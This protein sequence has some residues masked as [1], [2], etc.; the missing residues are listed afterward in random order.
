VRKILKNIGFKSIHSR[1]ISF[2]HVTFPFFFQSMINVIDYPLRA[3]WPFK[4]FSGTI[5]FYCTKD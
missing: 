3:I 2:N 4:L 1:G 5:A